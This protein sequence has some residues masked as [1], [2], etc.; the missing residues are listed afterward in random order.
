LLRLNAEVKE[1]REPIEKCLAKSVEKQNVILFILLG[2][3]RQQNK[4]RERG[5]GNE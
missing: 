5:N 2:I 4:E 3:E 1:L